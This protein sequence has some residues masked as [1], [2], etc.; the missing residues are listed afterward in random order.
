MLVAS[1]GVSTL[2][3]SF[4]IDHDASVT[5]TTAASGPAHHDLEAVLP[6]VAELGETLS[7]LVAPLVPDAEA[8]SRL[9]MAA[10]LDSIAILLADLV[11]FQTAEPDRL[12]DAVDR[13]LGNARS[14]AEDAQAVV[15]A[16]VGA[17]DL[18]V[19]ER[20]RRALARLPIAGILGSARLEMVRP[21]ASPMMV[22]LKIDD[23]G[24]VRWYY[25]DDPLPPTD[26]DACSQ[27]AL[28]EVFLQLTR[29][30]NRRH[31]QAGRRAGISPQDLYAARF[32]N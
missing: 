1:G 31:L 3:A 27:L 20:Q 17:D 22:H 16:V 12:P 29:I 2:G 24:Y 9:P 23:R 30:V 15:C 6:Q 18:A 11:A 10:I 19:R 8:R 21:D 5:D 14:V 32:D 26:V 28:A 4:G 25:E 13:V 7:G